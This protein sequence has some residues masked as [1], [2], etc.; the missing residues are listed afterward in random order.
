M[1]EI[2]NKKALFMGDLEKA[3][4]EI[5]MSLEKD[6]KVDVLKVG[7]H[8]SITSSSEEFIEKTRPKVAL[9]SVGNRF[10]SIPGKEVLKRFSSIYAKVYRTDKNGEINI[11]IDNTIEVKTIY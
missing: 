6:L 3:G 11:K 2:K 9:I 5:L 8:G 4:E 1:I 7:H 10:S